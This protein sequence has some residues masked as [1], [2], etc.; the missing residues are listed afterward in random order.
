MET[1]KNSFILNKFSEAIWLMRPDRL[2]NMIKFL[3]HRMNDSE[4][5]TKSLN[6]LQMEDKKNSLI[7]VQMSGSTAI[8]N[9]EGVMVPKCSW[10]DSICGFVSTLELNMKFQELVE[11][12]MVS[13]IVNYFDTPGGETTA[14]ME[15]AESVYS[16]RNKKE[17]VTFT[18]ADMC[19]A[20][21]W[22]G[23]SSS[24]VVCTPSST[25]GSIGV[26]IGLF[27]YEGKSLTNGA[28]ADGVPGDK[29]NVTFI[30]AGDNKLFGSPYIEISEAEKTYFQ[31]K[32]DRNYNTFVSSVSRNRGVSEEEVKNTKASYYDAA[33]APEWMYDI[34][35]DYNYLF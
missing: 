33:N 27:K 26:Y 13:K 31:E 20:G 24:K 16:A 11:D 6:L 15:F 21:Y 14:I 1:F 12:P 28:Y 17:I 25:I 32:V 5:I 30:Q 34:L 22:V 8:L 18:D 7:N 19:S 3:L 35:A 10:I 23:S 2:D 9:I 29:I 4:E